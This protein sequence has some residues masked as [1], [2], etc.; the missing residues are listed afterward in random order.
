MF[1]YIQI[2][3]PELKLKD[4][5]TYMGYYCGVCQ[6][7]GKQYGQLKRFFLSYEATYLAIVMDALLNED[8]DQKYKV[9]CTQKRWVNCNSKIWDYAP[10]INICLMVKKL[11]DNYQDDKS[12]LSLTLEKLIGHNK[13]YRKQ[14]ESYEP[15]VDTIANCLEELRKMECSEEPY[16]VD[17]LCCPFS[18]LLGSVMSYPFKGQEI[19]NATYDFGYYMGRIIYLIDALDDYKKDKKDGSFNPFNN[20]RSDSETDCS[21]ELF[22][23]ACACINMT[24]E[25][26]ALTERKLT[27]KK[28]QDI[29]HNVIQYGIPNRVQQIIKKKYADDF[30]R[31]EREKDEYNRKLQNTDGQQ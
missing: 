28:N 8:S 11:E 27:F 2:Y 18:E 29:I 9:G 30:E 24:Y 26:L 21:Y 1:G 12:I 17:E 6:Q 5:N 13:N 16:R 25:K 31:S 7:I 15:L 4:I 22:Q 3:K 23:K 14:A 20:F 19:Y 10:F